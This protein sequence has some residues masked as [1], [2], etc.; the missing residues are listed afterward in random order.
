MAD[1]QMVDPLLLKT[2]TLA[3]LA[4]N[5]LLQIRGGNERRNFL[6]GQLTDSEM[7]ID[8]GDMRVARPADWTGEVGLMFDQ[9]RFEVEPDSAT[10]AGLDC[11]TG[12]LLVADDQLAIKGSMGIGR[13]CWLVVG[14][15]DQLKRNVVE[16][17][18][19]FTRW[20]LVWGDKD[21]PIELFKFG[22]GRATTVPLS[23]V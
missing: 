5:Q 19:V 1:A 13:P 14:S 6:A 4:A 17:D 11:P 10:F 9:T 2:S 20:R 8:L 18:L 15:D 22:S 23:G 12:S 7:V 21:K 16:R 3:N